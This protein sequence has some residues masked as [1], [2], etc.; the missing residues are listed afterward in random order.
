MLHVQAL[1]IA[2]KFEAEEAATYASQ[3]EA[4]ARVALEL[5]QELER[6]AVEEDSR[7]AAEAVRLQAS[8]VEA[9][10]RWIDQVSTSWK[11]PEIFARNIGGGITIQLKLPQLDKTSLKLRIHPVTK[12]SAQARV[13]AE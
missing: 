8:E 13:L 12:V 10:M 4:D 7:S 5:A 9:L 3:I 2:R 11:T 6:A 1:Q